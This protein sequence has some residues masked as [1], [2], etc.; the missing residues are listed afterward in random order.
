MVKA[1]LCDRRH[2]PADAEAVRAVQGQ[3][4]PANYII[5]HGADGK[6][7]T[8]TP[9]VHMCGNSASPPPMAALASAN[10]P[11]RAAERQ[12]EAA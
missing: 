12:A 10:D 5:S 3:G 1:H 11:R 4:F 2:L 7:F 6:P 8:K 9:Q